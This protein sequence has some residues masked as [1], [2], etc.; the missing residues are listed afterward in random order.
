MGKHLTTFE[1]KPE[2][3]PREIVGIVGGNKHFELQESSR[4]TMFTPGSILKMN[5]V[6]SSAGNLTILTTAL[7]KA[8]RTIDPDEANSA[9]RMME[10]VVSSSAAGDRFNALL[11]G[12]LSAIALL[13]TA[14]RIVPD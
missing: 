3:V 7:R 2:F 10:D 5:V 6:N 13:L 12:A 14:A 4:P 11:F 9:F 1:G 8:I